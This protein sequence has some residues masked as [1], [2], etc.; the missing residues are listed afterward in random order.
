M[1]VVT[2]YNVCATIDEMPRFFSVLVRWLAFI[3][4]APM[5][6]YD[7]PVNERFELFNVTLNQLR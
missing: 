7:H 3:S 6:G 1:G 2:Y 4:L 5:D